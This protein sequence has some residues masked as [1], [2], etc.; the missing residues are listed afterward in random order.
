MFKLKYLAIVFF[1][2]V[3][4]AVGN[5]LLSKPPLQEPTAEQIAGGALPAEVAEVL[6]KEIEIWNEYSGRLE[7]VD[8]VEIKA[9]VGGAIQKILF[10]EGAYV[11]K[12]DPLFIIDQRQ[13][14]AELNKAMANMNATKTQ[15]EFANNEFTRAESLVNE[16]VITRSKFDEKLSAKQ[17]AESSFKA[18]EA[19]VNLAKL[20]L[21]YSTIKAPISGKISRAELT[22]GNLVDPVANLVL[23][24]IVSI[25][26]IYAEFN[27]DEQTYLKYSSI[28]NPNSGNVGKIPVQ[29][30]LAGEKEPSSSGFMKSFDNQLDTKT[31][32]IRARAI[33]ENKD[34]KLIPGL[35]AKIRLGNVDK[36]NAILITD[37]A[38]GTDQ[39]KKFVLVVNAENKIEYRIINLSQTYDGLRV[40]ESGLNSGEKIIVSGLFKYRPEMVVNPVIVSMN[41]SEKP[42]LETNP[43]NPTTTEKQENPE[44]TENPQ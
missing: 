2:F 11:Q 6:E 9:R 32:T 30:M 3:I 22:E 37:R 40:V 13:Y 14:I 20:N 8:K 10:Q 24:S 4:I 25:D 17:S 38:I 19:S 34:K 12:D 44:K 35:F 26:P 31:G 41:S 43:A 15:L 5:K 16:K 18:A 21:E 39:D 42:S 27:I 23:A 1:I 28:N 29:I 7:A 36:K 33:F